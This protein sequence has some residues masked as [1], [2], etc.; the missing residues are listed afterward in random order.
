MGST[1]PPDV[2]K[3]HLKKALSVEDVAEKEYHVRQAIQLL[4]LED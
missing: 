2:A 4:K 1:D 3:D